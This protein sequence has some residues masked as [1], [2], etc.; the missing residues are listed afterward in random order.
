MSGELVTPDNA[1]TELLLEIYEQAFMEVSAD[2]EGNGI[3]LL[4]EV[5]ARAFLNDASDRIQIGALY[6]IK[7][8]AQRIDRLEL[9]NRIND[10]FAVVRAAIDDDGDLLFDYCIVIRG[11]V[12][13]KAVVQA[14]RLF[15][16]LVTR[17]VNE[18]DE[19]E[20]VD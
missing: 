14:T 8:D 9:A 1:T 12:T 11:G 10:R 3:R 20:I 19:D 7:E 16:T 6:G 2:E 13:K 15:L 17:A 5:R 4:E 18:C